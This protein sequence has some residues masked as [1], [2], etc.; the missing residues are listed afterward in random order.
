MA[1]VG[2]VVVGWTLP[3]LAQAVAEQ[4]E[5]SC[6]GCH[7]GGGNVV[8]GS[9]LKLPDLKANGLDEPG[10]L[11]K[12]IYAGKGRMPGFGEECAPK[13]QHYFCIT[14]GVSWTNSH[15]AAQEAQL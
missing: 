2:A 12:L 3:A 11:Y 1:A 14:F 8:G 6:A 15:Y 10:A 9:T 13:V 7:V 4:F 5:S